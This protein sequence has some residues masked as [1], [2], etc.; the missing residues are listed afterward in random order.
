VE[1]PKTTR[2]EDSWP[3]PLVI[4]SVPTRENNV[5]L[6]SFHRTVILHYP[7]SSYT[8]I[9]HYIYNA[10]EALNCVEG[11]RQK[12]H[13]ID[14]FCVLS[15]KENSNV[16]FVYVTMTSDLSKLS[17][18]YYIYDFVAVISSIGG[19]IGMFLGYSCFGTISTFISEMYHH[20]RPWKT[21][22][23]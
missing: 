11:S 10:F 6:L 9:T 15:G 12:S 3:S 18:E 13:Y 5:F 17:S 21:F 7:P 20:T 1:T 23:K 19:G 8:G 2:G 14:N 4:F 16:T 22:L